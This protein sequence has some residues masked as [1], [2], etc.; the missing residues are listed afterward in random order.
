MPINLGGGGDLKPYI[1]WAISDNVWEYSTP[2]G[3]EEFEMK[4][5]TLVADIQGMTMG[6]MK[7]DVGVRDFQEWPS[8]FEPTPD[9]NTPQA[10]TKE[11]KRA[12]AMD[13][14]STKLWGDTKVCEF[15]GNAAGALNFAVNIYNQCEANHFDDLVAGKVPVIK[16]EDMPRKKVGLGNTRDIVFSIEKMIDRPEEF[17]RPQ[18]PMTRNGI[19]PKAAPTPKAEPAKAETPAPTED[20]F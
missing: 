7:I 16:I 20:E 6:W 19:A 11:W 15:S 5:A 1:R 10:L 3:R 18:Q 14:M 12:F 4:G 13:L 2:E 9:P 8:F 17:D